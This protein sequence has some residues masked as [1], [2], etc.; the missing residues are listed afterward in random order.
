[1]EYVIKETDSMPMEKEGC[2]EKVLRKDIRKKEYILMGNMRA[3]IWVIVSFVVLIIGLMFGNTHLSA[4]AADVNQFVDVKISVNYR[5]TEARRMLDMINDFRQG[6]EA[7]AWAE[8]NTDKI[9]YSNLGALKIDPVLEQIAM[10]RAAEIALSN[11]HLRP[12]GELYTTAYN[13]MTGGII[14]ENIAADSG[15]QFLTAESAFE[16]WKEDD[17]EYLSQGHRR[18]MLEQNFISVGIG[19]VEYQGCHYWVQEFSSGSY[20]QTLSDAVDTTA[21]EEIQLLSADISYIRLHR[22]DLEVY[23]PKNPLI[24]SGPGNFNLSMEDVN[25]SKLTLTMGETLSLKDLKIAI[26]VAGRWPPY[27]ACLLENDYSLTVKDEEIVSLEEGALSA[28]SV[29]TTSLTI[30][31]LGQETEMPIIVEKADSVATPRPS[32]IGDDGDD[33]EEDF[34]S[35]ENP[36]YNKKVKGIRIQIKQKNKSVKVIFRFKHVKNADGYR[37]TYARNKKFTKHR[38]V[39][40]A[41][42]TSVAVSGLQYKKTYYFKIHAYV[43]DS[44]GKR[45]YSADSAIVKIRM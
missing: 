30:T 28:Q 34:V 19:C 31:A 42:S 44:N 4:E 3:K 41:K 39:K 9:I 2:E 12:N 5:Q 22:A 43:L 27:I 23:H 37:I 1:M 6:D 24:I 7:W 13:G 36:L 21:V 35:I 25:P 26:G 10:L 45:H 11:S 14:A 38:K 40:N 33:D 16:A 29:G 20:G 32:I 17:C 18:S 15:V 8:N